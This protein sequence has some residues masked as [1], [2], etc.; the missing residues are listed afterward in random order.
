MLGPALSTACRIMRAGPPK[1][2]TSPDCSFTIF[3][4]SSYFRLYPK[5]AESPTEKDT[6]GRP[7]REGPESV[8]PLYT[9]L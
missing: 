7:S 8:S 6:T 2:I 3:S 5:S 1:T 9:G 4:G